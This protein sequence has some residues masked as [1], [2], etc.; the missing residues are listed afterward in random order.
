LERCFHLADRPSSHEKLFSLRTLFSRVLN[1][2]ELE[3]WGVRDHGRCGSETY[4]LSGLR[5]SALLGGSVT[6]LPQTIILDVSRDTSGLPRTPPIS[7]DN[8]FLVAASWPSFLSIL[9]CVP[10]VPAISRLYRQWPAI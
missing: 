4:I 5:G 6:I 9:F 1:R 10:D 8:T 3:L 2:S 7:D